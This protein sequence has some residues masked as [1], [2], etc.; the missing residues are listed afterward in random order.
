[1]L[2]S[3]S[4]VYADYFVMVQHC[5]KIV[6]LQHTRMLW[7]WGMHATSQWMRQCRV[8]QC[9]SATGTTV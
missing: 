2:N 5:V 1:M 8:V 3:V 9:C 7:V 6:C 4:Y